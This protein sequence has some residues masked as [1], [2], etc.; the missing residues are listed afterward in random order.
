MC[1][2]SRENSSLTHEQSLVL[3]GPHNWWRIENRLVQILS[4]VPSDKR[5]FRPWNKQCRGSEWQKNGGRSSNNTICGSAFLY[6]HRELP[7]IQSES[8]T[9][10]QTVTFR[11]KLWIQIFRKWAFISKG[12]FLPRPQ[13]RS[14]A[15]TSDRIKS[16]AKQKWSVFQRKHRCHFQLEM[17]LD[18][19]PPMSQ[20]NETI[21]I[22][23][24]SYS[25]KTCHPTSQSDI[26]PKRCVVDPRVMTF[27]FM[28]IISEFDGISF[29]SEFTHGFYFWYGL[30]FSGWPLMEHLSILLV[31]WVTQH[32]LAFIVSD[33]LV[34]YSS[35][36]K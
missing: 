30:P 34:R 12:L 11:L 8:M 35:A 2:N 16:D 9:S 19:P 7:A 5:A 26:A 27:C 22:G 23:K 17:Q 6:K 13:Q 36:S 14:S 20:N 24:K 31:W 32:S 28:P 1:S 10:K 15:R 29:C 3:C 4:E 33:L 21:K 25:Y 18:V